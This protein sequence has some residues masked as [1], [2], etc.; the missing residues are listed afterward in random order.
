MFTRYLLGY[1]KITYFINL[2]NISLILRKS[3]FWAF[4]L[5]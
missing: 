5:E 1:I 4:L 2:V 3:N